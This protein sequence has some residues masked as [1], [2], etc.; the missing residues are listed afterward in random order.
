M[1][2]Y[3]KQT[4]LERH[5]PEA[6]IFVAK[7][8]ICAGEFPA[9]EFR[10]S[11][12][13]VSFVGALSPAKGFHYLIEAFRSLPLSESELIL[14]TSPGHRPISSYMQHEMAR[15]QRIRMLPISV[16][17]NYGEVYSKSHV[18]VH[19]SLSDGY[20]YAVME[21][22]ASGLAVIVTSTTGSAQLIRDGE[23]GYIIPPR[24][25]EAIRDRLLHLSR[26]PALLRRLGAAARETIQSETPE[27]F[28]NFYAAKIQSLLSGRT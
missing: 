8:P 11:R 12:F 7:P 9:A 3:A 16:R 18:L 4:F 22:M 14:W 23:N 5:F 13:R 10:A 19:P 21:A 28:Q 2:E 25:P 20:S 17:D 6:R 1:S 26:N 27:A 24:D 15:D